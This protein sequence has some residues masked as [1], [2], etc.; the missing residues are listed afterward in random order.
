VSALLARVFSAKGTVDSMKAM[1]S[2]SGVVEV[3][4][5]PGE[6]PEAEEEEVEEG[7]AAIAL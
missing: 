1:S 2:C 3:G 4:E 5:A 6:S 7:A